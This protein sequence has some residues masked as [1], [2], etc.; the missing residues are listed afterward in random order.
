M[1]NGPCLVA[2]WRSGGF[3][4][5]PP[6]WHATTCLTVPPDWGALWRF[7]SWRVYRSWQSYRRHESCGSSGH[8]EYGIGW[9]YGRVRRYG[10]CRRYRPGV[11]KQPRAGVVRSL[12]YQDP[13]SCP[14]SSPVRDWPGMPRVRG[15]ILYRAYCMI[16]LGLLVMPHCRPYKSHTEPWRDLKGKQW[17]IW[18]EYPYY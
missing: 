18:P 15:Q 8:L 5:T 14:G 3:M 16:W 1:V 9:R 13:D 10:R 17:I 7:W 11:W 4:E 12:P 2:A 6:L